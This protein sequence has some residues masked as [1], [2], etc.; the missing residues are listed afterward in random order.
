MAAAP[1]RGV[2][3]VGILHS[4]VGPTAISETSV[5]EATL[6]AIEEINAAGILD[7]TIVPVIADGRSHAPTFAA[8]AER[9]ISHE[10]V[11]AIFGCWTAASRRSV[12]P[13]VA[14]HRSLLLYPASHEGLEASPNVIYADMAPNQKIAPTIKWFLDNRG[15]R[16]FLIGSE[17]VFPRTANAIIRDQLAY[18]GGQTVGEEYVPLGSHD[19]DAAIA[20]L[21]AARPQ[22]IV[23]SISGDS[24]VPFFQKLRA[25]GVTSARI[26]TLSLNLSENELRRLDSST[27]VGDYAVASYFQSLEPS[28]NTDFIHRFKARFGVDRVTDASIVSG[29]TAVHLWAQAVAEAGTSRPWQVRQEILHQK[30]ASPGGNVYV[31]ALNQNTWHAPRIGRIRQDGQLDIVWE[32]EALVHPVPYPVYRTRLQWSDFLRSLSALKVQAS[33]H[34]V[35]EARGG[36]RVIGS[37]DGERPRRKH[38]RKHKKK[39]HR[40]RRDVGSQRTDCGAGTAVQRGCQRVRRSAQQAGRDRRAQDQTIERRRPVQP[41]DQPET[42]RCLPRKR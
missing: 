31:D 39:R 5:V 42:L 2:I 9:L 27:M 19:F 32:S 26:P 29:F 7:E 18:L 13:V 11:Q 23:S 28:A 21:V 38:G 4:L 40:H 1:E 14:K 10:G 35:C 22:V 15:K 12:V 37:A 16:F 20:R 30:Y 34:Q 6:M 41:G 36:T 17:D 24:N 25:A 8:E 3:K 33:E